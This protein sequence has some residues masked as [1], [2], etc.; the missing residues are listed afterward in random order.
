VRSENGDNVS[1]GA[2]FDHV[3]LA[4]IPA[5]IAA[6]V[7]ELGGVRDDD[8]PGA[9]QRR[10]SIH[11]PTD[12]HQLLHRFA[13]SAKGRGFLELDEDNNLWLPGARAPA[14]V[15]QLGDWTINRVHERAA[16]LLRAQ[17]DSDPFEQLVHEVYR[18]DGGRVPRLIMSLVG[19]ILNKARRELDSGNPGARN[20]GR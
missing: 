16:A 11:V 14:A 20:R 10:Y 17:P 15:E 1:D 2:D 19:K 3:R 18:S 5:Q 9:F 4:E 8:L 6:L 12:E 7:S 13:W